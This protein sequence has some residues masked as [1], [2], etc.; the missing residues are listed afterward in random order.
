LEACLQKAADKHS[1]KT[2]VF[3]RA[4]D[5]AVPGRQ[6]ERLL[7]TFSRHHYPLALAVVPAWLTAPRWK[8]LCRMGMAGQGLWC[9]HQHGWRHQNHEPLGKK[10]EFGP[11]RSEEAQHRDLD[12]GHRRLQAIMGSAF[13]PIF[14]PPW[15]RCSKITLALLQEMGYKAVSRSQ[16]SRPQAPAGFPDH[17]VHVDLHTDRAPTAALGWQR[18]LNRL[19][20]GLRNP[21]CGIMIHHKRM[22]AAAFDFLDRL[23]EILNRQ[24]GIARADLRDLPKL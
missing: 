23:L 6:F 10:Q 7:E 11:C 1:D 12:R 20:E 18:L 21:V 16:G 17:A 3:F 15:N 19:T 13:V 5:I 4:D 9:W 8:A 2:Q 24:P 22:N 14:T